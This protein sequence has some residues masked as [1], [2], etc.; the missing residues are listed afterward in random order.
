MRLDLY[1]SSNFG[2]TRN[3]AQFLIKEGLVTVDSRIEKKPSYEIKEW[4]NIKIKEDPRVAYVSRS[5][6][7]LQSFLDEIELNLSNKK[8][9]DVWSSTW[10]FTQVLLI[11]WAKEVISV[12]VWTDQL[13]PILRNDKRVISFENTDIRDFSKKYKKRDLDTISVDVSFIS[14]SKII[15]S[16]FEL[17]KEGTEYLIL[18]KPQFEVWNKNLKKTGL[19]INQKV[20]TEAIDRFKLLCKEKGL[21]IKKISLSSIEGEA[22]NKEYM[23]YAMK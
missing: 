9:L 11:N 17:W 22:W 2:H 15:D 3:R 12:D 13:N 5:A 4:T 21:K 1:I 20:I 6:I 10:W 19:P 18:F 14:L 16:I 23:I 8:C 7:K